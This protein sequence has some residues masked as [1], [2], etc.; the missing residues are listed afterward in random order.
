MIGSK[1]LYHDN[2]LYQKYTVCPP[3]GACMSHLPP[4]EVLINVSLYDVPIRTIVQLTMFLLLSQQKQQNMN[5]FGLYTFMQSVHVYLPALWTVAFIISIIC[6]QISQH[7][8]FYQLLL[9]ESSLFKKFT[10]L[11]LRH[12]VLLKSRKSRSNLASNFSGDIF[13]M[14]SFNFYWLST[15]KRARDSM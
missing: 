9:T 14:C 10:F 8:Q 4:E 13:H 2:I 7:S 12:R 11:T 5:K 6:F 15:M 3:E 1:N